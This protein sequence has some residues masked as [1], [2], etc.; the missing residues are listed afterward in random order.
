MWRGLETQDGSRA[1][2][3]SQGSLR[4]GFLGSGVTHGTRCFERKRRER[5]PGCNAERAGMDGGEER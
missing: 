1:G 4:L 2:V 3:A 5:R